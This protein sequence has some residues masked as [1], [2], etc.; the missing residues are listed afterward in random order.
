LADSL[1]VFTN[2]GEQ[3]RLDKF[4]VR[5][6]PEYSRSRIQ[7]LIKDGF[8]RVEDEVVT[9]PSLFV[10][11]TQVVKVAIPPIVPAD[12]SGENIPLNIIYENDD[13]LI[14]DKQAG[15]VV[16][17][18]AGHD[19]GTL[20]NAALG[21]DPDLEGVGGELRPGIVH[22]LDKDT[23]G[24]IVIAKNDQALHW[25]QDQFRLRKVKKEYMALVDGRP[26][27][28]KGRIEASIGRDSAHRK[29]MAI[30]SAE[31]GREAV[32]EY[33]TVEEFINHTLLKVHPLTGRTHQI[34]LHLKLLGT[35]IVGDIL[36]GHRHLSLDIPR[37][38]LHAFQLEI[39]LPH[40]TAA[41]TF[42]APLPGELENVLLYLRKN[43]SIKKGK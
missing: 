26:P 5:N 9:K 37:Q 3:E 21:H 16:H 4:I 18:S 20:V 32:S 43:F 22:R 41:R 6:F 17:P 27:T 31:K 24:I 33:E 35:P 2:S 25:L 23:S 8:V 38:F 12:V 28:P 40:E 15:M 1:K 14:I 39:T 42:H 7:G 30:V 19:S 11:T 34:R 13:L 36:Y 29:K 10:E